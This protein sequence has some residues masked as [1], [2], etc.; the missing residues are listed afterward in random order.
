MTIDMISDA[1][2]KIRR[3]DEERQR[4]MAIGQHIA[5]HFLWNTTTGYLENGWQDLVFGEEEGDVYTAMIF[6]PCSNIV[7]INSGATRIMALEAMRDD[8]TRFLPCIKRDPQH[9]IQRWLD[10][11][12]APAEIFADNTVP[13]TKAEPAASMIPVWEVR[14]TSGP[15][16]WFTDEQKMKAFIENK[17]CMTTKHH[18]YV[19]LVQ[20]DTVPFKLEK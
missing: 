10:Y 12:P 11:K 20:K 8:L 13:T 15:D 9:V 1:R 17:T 14:L 4:V 6:I 2:W 3:L 19:Y 16:S 7:Q 18:G 5:L